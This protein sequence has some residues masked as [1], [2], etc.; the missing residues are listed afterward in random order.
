[1][2]KKIAVIG[3]GF[4]GL[5]A[6]SFLAKG[7]CEV[8]IYEKNETIGGRARKFSADGFT[9][10]M[11]PSWYWMPDVFESFFQEF[12]HKVEDFYRLERLDPSYQVFFEDKIG[13]DIPASMD[14]MYRLFDSIESG[15]SARLKQF[16][17][18]AAYKYEV[19]IND[20]V[21]KP[22]RSITEFLDVRLAIGVFKLHV[23]QSISKYIR[24]YFS[25]PKLIQLLEFPVL[26]LG[27]KPQDTPALYSLMNY[28]DI[29]LGTWYPQGGMNKIVEG[30]EKVAIEQGVTIKTSTTVGKIEVE[31]GAVKGIVVNGRLEEYDYVVGGADYHHVEQNLLEPKYRKYDEKYWDSR[32]MAPS[33]LIFYL[34]IDKELEKL[35]HHNL[36]FDESFDTHAEEIYDEPQWPSKPLFYVC[37]PSKTDETVAPKGKE[38]IF[39]LIP[40]APDLKDTEEERKKYYS[41]VM[42]RMER[43]TGQSIREHVV[44][45]RSYAHKDFI[46]DYNSFKGNAYGLANTLKQTAILKPSIVN[47]KVKRLYYTGQLTVPGPGVPPSLISGQV[48]AKEI[49]KSIE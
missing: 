11:G 24:K 29:S 39:I 7:G 37:C 13:V 43:L 32:A 18:E 23:F 16:L 33:S 10:D 42:D 48:T 20:L 25:H 12:G 4:A 28:A 31:N 35:R 6:A 17:E 46:N 41:M 38:N 34:G 45:Q 36:F 3:S 21:Y 30:M 1:M 26:F 14:E 40:V 8:T 15:S 19:G 27:A 44:Y 49:L 47:K 22:G 2:K 5:S 9:F